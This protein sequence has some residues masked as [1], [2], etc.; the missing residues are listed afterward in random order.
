M[1]TYG[2][3]ITG[4][5]RELP[6]CRLSDDL[7]IAYFVIFG[8]VELTRAC[9]RELLK[10][11]PPHDIMITAESKGIPLIYEMARQNNESDYL[12]ARK[13]PKLYMKKVFS[14][15]VQAITNQARQSLYIDSNDA[16][17]MRGKRVL[18]VDDVISTG[19]SIH[20]VEH[21]IREVGGIVAGKMAIFAEGS[22]KDRDDIT[23]L[24]HLP[25]F[26]RHGNPIE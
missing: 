4:L 12:I 2:V 7:Y 10:K 24:E 1:D 22:A 9:A 23:Y 25:L 13:S 6:I 11:A 15:E 8:D 19:E 5:K 16:D 17:K 14:V 21:L 20:A 3:T 26:D 18:I